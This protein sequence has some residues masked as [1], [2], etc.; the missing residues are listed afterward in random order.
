MGRKLSLGVGVAALAG[1]G[2]LAFQG[3]RVGV[4]ILVLVG[5][6]ALAGYLKS[7]PVD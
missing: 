4:T 2:V 5:A 1:A 7:K 3:E 6:S